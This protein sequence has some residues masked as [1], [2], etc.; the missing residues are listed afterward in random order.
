MDAGDEHR[1]QLRNLRDFLLV[2][3]R[4]TQLCFQHC[5]CNL[6][7]RLLTGEECLEGCTGKLLRSNHRLMGAYLGMVPTL[8]Q[9]RR[10]HPETPPHTQGG[11]PETPSPTQGVLQPP[12]PLPGAASAAH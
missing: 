1:Q 8:L 4:M 6:N 11:P 3:N 7:Y 5:V 10:D 9:R 2:Y 12:E